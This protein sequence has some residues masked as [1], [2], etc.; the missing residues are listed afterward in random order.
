[1]TD[2]YE[3]QKGLLEWLVPFARQHGLT[4][5][6]IEGVVKVTLGAQPVEAQPSDPNELPS[7]LCHCGHHLSMHTMAG[8]GCLECDDGA[9][10]CGKPMRKGG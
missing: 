9:S 4:H 10:L 3:L 8:G 7:G 6:D 1:M 2:H 5:V